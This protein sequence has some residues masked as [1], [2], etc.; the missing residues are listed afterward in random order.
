V[1]VEEIDKM[2]TG[3]ESCDLCA[4]NLGTPYIDHCHISG[5]IRGVLCHRCNTGL[6]CFLDKPVLLRYAADYIDRHRSKEVD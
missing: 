1:S 5:K 4:G 6:G 2:I 3:K